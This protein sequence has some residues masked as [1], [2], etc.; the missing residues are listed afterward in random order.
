MHSNQIFFGTAQ[1]SYEPA[2]FRGQTLVEHEPFAGVGKQLGLQQLLFL[3]QTHGTDGVV[4][5][6]SD[7]NFFSPFVVD[8]DYLLTNMPGI[9]LGVSTADCLPVVMIDRVRSRA[10][11]FDNTQDERGEVVG[12]IHAGW[13][14]ARS[15]IVEKVI[16]RAQQEFGCQ[17]EDLEFHFGPSA[18]G[19]CYEVQPPFKKEFSA[20]HFAQEAFKEKGGR[21][22]FDL[23]KFAALHLESL[24]VQKIFLSEACTICMT[25]YCSVRKN[26]NSPVRQM[27]V[28]TPTKI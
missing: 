12:V 21:L 8:G 2:R 6:Q 22:F 20:Y 26:A 5:K 24:G 23:P 15:G 11:S 7:G 16:E 18:H 13:R 19:C 9:G 3:H 4:I 10:L 27:T 1:H 14:G 28:V 17:V 25:G